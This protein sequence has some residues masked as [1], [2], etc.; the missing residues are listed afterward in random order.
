MRLGVEVETGTAVA[1]A[2]G[3][4]GAIS[5]GAPEGDGVG[6]EPEF[7]DVGEGGGDLL[8][9]VPARDMRYTLLTFSQV[10]PPG[11]RTGEFTA[12]TE[13]HRAGASGKG[14]NG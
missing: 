3:R 13:A 4:A 7:D 1:T 11:Q 5:T 8:G 2:A 14:G 12:A 6:V 9:K 10:T